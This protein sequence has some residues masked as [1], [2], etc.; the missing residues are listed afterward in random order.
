MSSSRAE[1]GVSHFR[2]KPPSA[3]PTTIHVPSNSEWELLYGGAPVKLRFV[4]E[5]RIPVC[6]SEFVV[7]DKGGIVRCGRGRA[8][9]GSLGVCGVRDG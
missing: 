3:P 8:Q 2:L 1:L 5:V 4:A 7:R 6:V 9:C